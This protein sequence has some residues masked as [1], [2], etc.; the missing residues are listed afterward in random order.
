[1]KNLLEVLSRRMEMREE[2]VGHKLANK[3]VEIFQFVGIGGN[4]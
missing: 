3:S 1:M 2:R 4:I